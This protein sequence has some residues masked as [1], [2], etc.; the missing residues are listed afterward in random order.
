MSKDGKAV[1]GIGTLMNFDQDSS[2]TNVYHMAVFS[3][4]ID[5]NHDDPQN[6]SLTITTNGQ[7]NTRTDDLTNTSLS[8]SNDDNTSS[9]SKTDKSGSFSINT[10]YTLAVDSLTF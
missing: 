8:F 1:V 3:Q 4:T 6:D 5:G 9:T 7:I 2:N 10:S